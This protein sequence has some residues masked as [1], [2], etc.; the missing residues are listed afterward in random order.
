MSAM[1]RPNRVLNFGDFPTGGEITSEEHMNN[2]VLVSI[3][4]TTPKQHLQLP[5]MFTQWNT[6]IVEIRNTGDVQFKLNGYTVY[7]KTMRVF[8]WVATAWTLVSPAPYP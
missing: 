7:P 5:M 6:Q 3:R 1:Q 8:A 4:Q 2:A